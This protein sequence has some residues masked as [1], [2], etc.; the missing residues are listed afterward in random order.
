MT[1]QLLG[2]H[3]QSAE[4]SSFNVS[5]YALT[6]VAE[7]I[8]IANTPDP[9]LP[10]HPEG[11]QNVFEVHAETLIWIRM[12]RDYCNV[13][14][15]HGVCSRLRVRGR[16]PAPPI[17][18]GR[19][20]GIIRLP[21]M[22]VRRT[23]MSWP[24]YTVREGRIR[25]INIANGRVSLSEF[26]GLIDAAVHPVPTQNRVRRALGG[27]I[28]AAGGRAQTRRH[29]SIKDGGPIQV[30]GMDSGLLTRHRTNRFRPTLPVKSTTC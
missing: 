17:T 16:L 8:Q 6:V 23:W 3:P 22:L 1:E 9:L 12:N 15:F 2:A 24:H 28:K 10:I 25:E 27:R 30:S 18:R 21:R 4:T 5:T 19:I 14:S 13:L 26:P 20:V 7:P 29:L 11:L